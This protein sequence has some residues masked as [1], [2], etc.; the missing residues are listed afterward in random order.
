MSYYDYKAIDVDNELLSY[1]GI[2]PADKR[3]RYVNKS[4]E[5]LKELYMWA[6]RKARYH[7]QYVDRGSIYSK[8]VI[9]DNMLWRELFINKAEGYAEEIKRRADNRKRPTLRDIAWNNRIRGWLYN[10]HSRPTKYKYLVTKFDRNVYHRYLFLYN[11]G[12][13]RW[14]PILNYKFK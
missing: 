12:L 1:T 2:T 14:D 9:E 3:Y 8:K 10:F 13:Y 7:S 5:E 4:T 6:K 11:N